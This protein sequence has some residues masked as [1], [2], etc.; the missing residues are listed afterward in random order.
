MDTIT[1][2]TTHVVSRAMPDGPWN[3]RIVWKQKTLFFVVLETADGV[4]G[5]GEGWCDGLTPRVLEAL[6]EDL[7]PLLLGKSPHM[8]NGL[9]DAVF[10]K[11]IYSA[12]P[13]LVLAAL[14]ALDIAL[15]D[16]RGKAL[17]L[18]VYRLLGGHADKVFVYASGGLYGKDK[19]LDDLA[20]EMLGYVAQGFTAVKLKVGGAS[21]REDLWR[22]AAVREAVG[23]DIRIMADA[24]YM[25]SVADALKLSRGMEA[26]DVYFLEAP[27]PPL[28]VAG[29]AEVRQRGPTP[30]AGNEF[31]YGRHAFR[32]LMEHRAVDVAHLD[33]IVCGGISE[34]YKI[35]ALTSAWHVPCSFH[36]S[37]SAVC[38][39][40]N[41]HAGAA[42]SNC[43][44]VEYHMVH[45]HLFDALPECLRQVRDGWVTLPDTPGLGLHE[46]ILLRNLH[47]SQPPRLP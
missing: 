13:G 23:P 42:T 43:D 40:A 7:G 9:W 4:L 33:S 5:V 8:H 37:S 3:P 29:L 41:L 20:A 21:V 45:Q 28:D 46:A 39:A 27:V 34:A 12:K 14:S 25:L 35:A 2:I 15:W 24:L 30:V 32:E 36:A 26:S 31:A 16:A 38:F 1:R 10:Q 47:N 22:V 44:S 18:P 11:S 17:G 19:T 6:V